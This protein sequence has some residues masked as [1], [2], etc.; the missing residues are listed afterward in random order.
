MEAEIVLSVQ[1]APTHLDLRGPS[2]AKIGEVV[3]YS[4]VTANS[5]PP[6]SIRWVVGNETKVPQNSRS[7]LSPRGGWVTR[8]NITVML[9]DSDRSKLITC[10]AYTNEVNEVKSESKMLSVIYP[11]GA[12]QIQGLLGS[13]GSAEILTA[14]SMKRLTCTSIAGNPLAEL[15][16]FVEPPNFNPTKVGSALER[17]ELNSFY[18]TRDNFATAELEYI[19]KPEDNGGRLTCEAT[20]PALSRPMRA[21]AEVVVLFSARSVKISA[22]PERPRGGKNV[23]LTC[24]TDPA[25]SNPASAVSWWHNGEKLEPVSEMILDGKYGGFVTASYLQIRLTPQHNGAVITCEAVNQKLG[26]EIHD[27]LTLNVERKLTRF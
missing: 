11:P 26:H 6:A 22:D 20:S 19:P 27:A 13:H 14:G 17:R 25:G 2:E 9:T 21:F 1:F 18:S 16:W 3:T 8:S 5:N 10:K 24:E 4:C 23:T 7:E 12:P 15:R